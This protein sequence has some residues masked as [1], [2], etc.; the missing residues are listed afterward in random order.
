MRTMQGM[1]LYIV[2]FAPLGLIYSVFK[3]ARNV[4]FIYYIP[5]HAWYEELS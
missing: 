3:A 1:L 4:I 5:R 2:Y